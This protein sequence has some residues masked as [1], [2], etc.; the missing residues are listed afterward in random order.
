[1][2]DRS[3]VV[4][5]IVIP[6]FWSLVLPTSAPAQILG[7]TE[8]FQEQTQWCWAGCSEALIEYYGL[9]INQ[10]TIA[11]WTR[12]QDNWGIADCCQ[13]ADAS[14][15]ICNQ[16]NYMYGSAGSLQNIL[17]NWG[18]ANDSYGRALTEEEIQTGLGLDLAFVI[19]WGWIGGGGHFLVG[20]GIDGSTIYYM[21]PW[22]GNG[23][24][25]ATYGWVVSSDDHEW[26]HSLQVTGSEAIPTLSEWGLIL[27][28]LVILSLITAIVARYRTSMAWASAGRSFSTPG[29]AIIF[30]RSTYL[31]CLA[32]VLASA[33]AVLG[34]IYIASGTIPLRDV[35]GTLL[36]AALMAY[37]VHLWV[38]VCRK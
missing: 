11:N 18:V 3:K 35:I 25:S 4:F 5:L 36:S 38:L 31:R 26:T 9:P 6:V 14:G 15:S 22:P 19:R 24:N 1:M 10:C 21:D 16:P 37:I 7:V 23:Y 2:K 12:E 20:R 27:F 29:K 28:S 13:P 30:R 32:I 33:C 17:I 8:I 34:V